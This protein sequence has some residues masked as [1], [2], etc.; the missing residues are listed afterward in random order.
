MRYN[1]QRGKYALSP[2][3]CSLCIHGCRF[4][5]N[6]NINQYFHGIITSKFIIIIPS[7]Q[8]T[9]QFCLEIPCV[10][11]SIFVILVFSI[12]RCLNQNQSLC[13]WVYKGTG[14]EYQLLAGPLYIV[15]FSI[16]GIALGLFILSLNWEW[17]FIIFW[18]LL[19]C[20]FF[21]LNFRITSDQPQS[22]TSDLRSLV[23]F[24]DNSRRIC[25]TLLA[26]CCS[27]LPPW[28]L[29]SIFSKC[30][31]IS[32]E[33]TLPCCVHV[34]WSALSLELYFAIKLTITRLLCHFSSAGCVPFSASIIA[35]LFPAVSGT[36][37]IFLKCHHICVKLA[38]ISRAMQPPWMAFDCLGNPSMMLLF[39][40]INKICHSAM[41]H[42][43]KTKKWY[44]VWY[45]FHQ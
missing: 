38:P 18:Q 25:H 13:K 7:L 11:L 41:Q 17:N 6:I 44:V 31:H 26:H 1:Y 42:D 8:N 16:S 5:C 10:K 24:N 3:L 34:G 4:L 21:R 28:N 35:D 12:F 15:M 40:M 43:G 27:T 36:F 20:F 14:L 19:P 30:L 23:G 45:G 39:P 29:V 37:D 32:P 2:S 9:H 33:P 22:Y